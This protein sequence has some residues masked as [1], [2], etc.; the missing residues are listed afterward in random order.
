MPLIKIKTNAIVSPKNLSEL[1]SE[2]TAITAD[3]LDKPVSI[4]MASAETEAAMMFG[5]K[6]VPTALFEIEA[7][8]YEEGLSQGLVNALTDLAGHLLKASPENVFIKISNV[9]RGS[10]AGSKRI[11]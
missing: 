6:V 7:L 8:D 10:W 5:G 1:L 3:I 11:F 2:S 9:P 4:F